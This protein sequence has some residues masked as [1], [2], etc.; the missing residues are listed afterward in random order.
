M[1]PQQR[2]VARAAVKRSATRDGV[3]AVAGPA[4]VCEE[5]VAARRAV[6]FLA[7]AQRR[8]GVVRFG[9]QP[10]AGIEPRCVRAVIRTESMSSARIV[11]S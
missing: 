5:L 3:V 11:A 6:E 2:V 8:G 10:L 4:E 7:D 9:P 1:Q